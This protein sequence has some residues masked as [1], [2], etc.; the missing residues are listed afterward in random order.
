M[1]HLKV[2]SISICTNA[3]AKDLQTLKFQE[4]IWARQTKCKS[5][6]IENSTICT[7][8]NG[9]VDVSTKSQTE[10]YIHTTFTCLG[11]NSVSRNLGIWIR[12]AAAIAGTI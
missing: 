2:N 10:I 9:H 11:T 12:K 1:L 3:V 6:T 7:L 4:H 5:N 8:Y